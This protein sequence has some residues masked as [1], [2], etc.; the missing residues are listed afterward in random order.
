M[1]HLMDSESLSEYNR[2]DGYDKRATYV[3]VIKGTD[4]WPPKQG[5]Q[6]KVI[7]SVGLSVLALALCFAVLRLAS[8]PPGTCEV[9][10]VYHCYSCLPSRDLA[11][12]VLNS[13]SC[14]QSRL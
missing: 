9:L 14:Y 4:C 3:F 6:A 7:Y 11:L 1:W 13:F 2:I 12:Q 5:Q 8:N 10:V